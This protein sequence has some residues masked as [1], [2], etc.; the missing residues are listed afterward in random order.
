MIR[1][2]LV[3]LDRVDR[4]TQFLGNLLVTH[5]VQ[6]HLVDLLTR[7]G[8]LVKHGKQYLKYL[9]FQYPIQKK[10]R[11]VILHDHF[12]RVFILHLPVPDQV[13]AI[14]SHRLV[15]IGFHGILH[16]EFRSLLPQRHESILHDIFNSGL[17]IHVFSGKITQ[18]HHV[19]VVQH[20]KSLFPSAR[21]LQNY[22]YLLI[23]QIDFIITRLHIHPFPATRFNVV[24]LSHKYKV[25]SR[26]WNSNQ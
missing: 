1:V 11:L 23:T 21:E 25:F 4:N 24:Y 5:P 17:V 2:I 18:R 26:K 12:L 9:G 13:Q 19:T 7:R 16:P 10:L 3:L 6:A 20:P 14:I 22:I 15:Q 8:Q